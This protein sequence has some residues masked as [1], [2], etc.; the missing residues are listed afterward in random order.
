M[1]SKLD[2]ARCGATFPIEARHTEVIRRDFD[3]E[4][5]PSRIEHLCGH[6][7]R[8]YEAFIEQV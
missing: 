3:G 7:L 1:A 4:P 5:L 8:E 6:C 2:C